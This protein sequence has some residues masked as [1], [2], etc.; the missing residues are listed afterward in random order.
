MNGQCCKSGA[1][2]RTGFAA[3]ILPG[4]ALALLPKCPLCLAAWLGLVTG[5]GVSAAASVYLREGIIV[6]CVAG[7]L[8]A[9]RL[10]WRNFALSKRSLR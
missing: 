4:A 2:R 7:L 1:A 9:S 5:V 8:S 3:S 10:V 6:L